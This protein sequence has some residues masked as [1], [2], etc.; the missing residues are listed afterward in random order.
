M[1]SLLEFLRTKLLFLLLAVLA[2]G[3]AVGVSAFKSK[4]VKPAS[5]SQ[6]IN[7]HYNSTSSSLTDLKNINNWDVESASCSGSGIP[8][9]IP[10]NGDRAAFA[11]YLNGFT[12][13]A[14][15]NA[16]AT[17]QQDGD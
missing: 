9:V 13:V 14:D 4:E 11:T 17:A 10:F 15:M 3:M 7:Y 8:C 5:K 1:S 6:A 2:I 12:S 16:V